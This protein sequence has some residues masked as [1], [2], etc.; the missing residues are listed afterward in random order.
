VRQYVTVMETC[1]RCPEY[2]EDYFVPSVSK[3][4]RECRFFWEWHREV[5]EN[6]RK[7]QES[8]EVR[9]PQAPAPADEEGS[10]G[11]ESLPDEEEAFADSSHEFAA[12]EELHHGDGTLGGFLP[13]FR[14]A[15]D[16]RD[17]EEAP[18]EDEGESTATRDEE[19]EE[20]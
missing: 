16:E 15:P 17:S 19:D 7:D 2:K 11:K 3:S 9:W 13:G 10:N 18:E 8:G 14:H 12:S 1:T 4:G 5:E 6:I 20:D